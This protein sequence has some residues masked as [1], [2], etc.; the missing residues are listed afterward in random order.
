MEG[1]VEEDTIGRDPFV[2]TFIEVCIMD[3]EM[4]VRCAGGRIEGEGGR[5]GVAERKDLC[6]PSFV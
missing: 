2:Q 1:L 4:D 3:V 5:R 6:C